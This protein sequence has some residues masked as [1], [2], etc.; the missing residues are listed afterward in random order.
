MPDLDALVL[1]SKPRVWATGRLIKGLYY[2]EA[3]NEPYALAAFYP[4]CDQRLEQKPFLVMDFRFSQFLLDANRDGCADATGRL[5]APE[6]DP[7]DF[8]P[9]VDGAE[10]L[11]EEDL[12]GRRP[13]KD[14]NAM[15]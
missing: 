7:A 15:P 3:P 8:L 4:A 13:F 6:I 12:I 1:R 14:W 2:S 9:A 11:C 10:E 5:P